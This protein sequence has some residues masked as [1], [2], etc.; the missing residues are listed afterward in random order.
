MRGVEQ[1]H[2]VVD[3][4]EL[5]QHGAEVADVVT[6]VAQRGVVEG[7]QPQA[8]DAEPFQVVQLVGEAAQIADAVAI[9]IVEGA[10]QYFVEDR[11]LEPFR[12]GGRGPRVLEILGLRLDQV[13]VRRHRRH[14]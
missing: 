4:A 9:R 5:R 6:A 1:V 13:A 10:Y 8:V 14:R 2:E 3:G 11:G 7:R 12:L